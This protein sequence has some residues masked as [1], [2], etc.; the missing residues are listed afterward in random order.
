MAMGW[1]FVTGKYV[2]SATSCK[3]KYVA[4]HPDLQIQEMS[5]EGQKYVNKGKSVRRPSLSE[6]VVD[7]LRQQLE[8]D[9][10]KFDKIFS[11]VRSS[12]CNMKLNKGS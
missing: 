9:M 4:K 5:I 1:T 6:I 7:D 3:Q 10:Q 2:Y 8:Q 12:Y 11:A